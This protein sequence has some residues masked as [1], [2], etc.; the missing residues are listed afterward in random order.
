MAFNFCDG[1]HLASGTPIVADER[2][3]VL[4]FRVIHARR[5]GETWIAYNGSK[6]KGA[7]YVYYGG[8]TEGPPLSTV[9]AGNWEPKLSLLLHTMKCPGGA[10]EAE[11]P[12]RTAVHGGDLFGVGFVSSIFH[13][14]NPFGPDDLFASYYVGW[15]NIEKPGRYRIYTASSEASFVFLDNKLLCSWPGHHDSGGGRQGQHGGD[16]HLEKGE[17]K[18]EYFHAKTQGE[19]CMMLGWTPPGEQGWKVIPETAF[20]HTPIAHA[21]APERRGNAPLAAFSWQQADQLLLDR[22]PETRNPKPETKGAKEAPKAEPTDI[23]Q[24]TRITFHSRFRNVPE[25]AKVVWEYGDGAIGTGEGKEHIY[26]GEGPFTAVARIV[27]ADGKP[28]DSFG[29]L[30][31]PVEALKN[32]TI[33]DKDAVRSYVATI[34]ATDASKLSERTLDTLWELVE[35]EEDAER[36][37]P[38]TETYANRF[39]V[40]TSVGWHAA[41]RL[42]LAVSVK[43]PERAMKIYAA[44][45]PEAPTRLDAARVQME[46]IE[47]LLHKLKKPDAALELAKAVIRSRSGLEDR[48]AAVKIGD[49]YRAQGDFAKAEEAYRDAQKI[50]YAEMDRRTIAVRQGGYLETV[51]SH[52]ENGSLRAAREGLVMWEIEH[53]IGKLSGDLILMTAKYFDKLGEPDRALAE[54]EALVKLNPLTPY[55]PDAELLM[56]RAHRKLGNATKARELIE[57]V[58]HEYP[59]SRAAQQAM[60]E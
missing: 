6:A 8:K 13:G 35:T 7:V 3:S 50:T 34:V 15:L 20:L 26:V 32:F 22:K 10:L 18:V 12:I 52:I 36:I 54:L 60:K 59:K 49:V 25:K 33:L 43:E 30:V 51:W 31:T 23:E 47:L 37:R 42:A 27:G 40:K 5:G 41:D 56:A 55:L 24:F 9:P 2:E 28:L 14:V 21:E 48:V 39:G 17:H 45:V 4:P 11:R 29:A 38:F 53:P 1:G 16:I 58:L 19:T 57:K 44:L 46:R